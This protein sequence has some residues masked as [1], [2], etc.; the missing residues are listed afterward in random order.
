MG[1]NCD[2]SGYLNICYY[3][4]WVWSISSGKLTAAFT[5]VIS[6]LCHSFEINIVKFSPPVVTLTL[7][8]K[9]CIFD[10]FND[11]SLHSLFLNMC[12]LY[13]TVVACVNKPDMFSL[14]LFG[15]SL[16]NFFQCILI[17]DVSFTEIRCSI[18]A[19]NYPSETWFKI[20]MW[21]SGIHHPLYGSLIVGSFP[22]QS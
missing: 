3:G 20:A 13:V 11:I 5:F 9:T 4:H 22:V 7:Q 16:T 17:N 2:E 6:F 12:S 21:D 14:N 15:W 19:K 10:H 1:L 18:P 8:T